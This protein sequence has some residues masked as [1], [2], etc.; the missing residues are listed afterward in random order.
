M[1]YC[2]YMLLCQDGSYYTGYTKDPKNRL[3]QHL[4]GTGSRYT[5][6]KKPERIVYV[7]WFDTRSD[8]MRQEKK[9]KHLTHQEKSK[10]INK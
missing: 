6:M 4:N 7:E 8:A 3:K 5:H 2:V 1:G 10:L 9:I